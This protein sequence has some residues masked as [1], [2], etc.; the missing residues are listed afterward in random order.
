MQ[1][2]EIMTNTHHHMKRKPNA[3]VVL[4]LFGRG[5]ARAAEE[6]WCEMSSSF[7]LRASASVLFL[8]RVY[9]LGGSGL[10]GNI[11]TTV[12]HKRGT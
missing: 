4:S 12:P 3:L 9:N 1:H 6:G 7:V 5:L 11:S 8:R 10:I 2:Y